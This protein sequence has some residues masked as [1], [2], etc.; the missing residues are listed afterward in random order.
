MCR[1]KINNTS[2]I[3]KL[4]LMKSIDAWLDGKNNPRLPRPSQ[5]ENSWLIIW[6]LVSSV[7]IDGGGG[8][9][10]R[11]FSGEAVDGQRPR[12]HTASGKQAALQRAPVRVLPAVSLQQLGPPLAL[13]QMKRPTPPCLLSQQAEGELMSSLSGLEWSITSCNYK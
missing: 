8:S 6:W 10:S 7:L 9:L 1:T 13:T 12:P 3:T 5:L 4:K 11:V 2:I